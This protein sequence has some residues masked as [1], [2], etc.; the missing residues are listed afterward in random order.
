M[1]GFLAFPIL[2]LLLFVTAVNAHFATGLE[3]YNSGDYATAIREWKPLA[4]KGMAD[5][6]FNLAWM[7]Y[8]GKGVKGSYT[9]AANWN[10]LAA[11]V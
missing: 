7:H 11:E 1:K 9:T 2:L 10:H 5:A 4:E 8:F 6:Q 3:A